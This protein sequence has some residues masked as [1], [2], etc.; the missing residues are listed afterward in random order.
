MW[1]R[2]RRPQASSSVRFTTSFLARRDCGR[3]W[4]DAPECFWGW[5]RGAESNCLRR[6]FQGRALPM[7][8]LGTGTIKD[9]TEKARE[10]KAKSSRRLN[11]AAR[12]EALW[13]ADEGAAE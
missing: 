5:C 1:K 11:D 7:S 10:W 6:P 2:P 12:V 8:Y 13:A 4:R 9:S 3:P